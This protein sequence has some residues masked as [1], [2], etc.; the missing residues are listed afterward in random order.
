MPRAP[1]WKEKQSAYLQRCSDRMLSSGSLNT[2]RWALDQFYYYAVDNGFP[3]NPSKVEPNHVRE[4]Y[5]HL[6]DTGIRTATQ[7]SY[8]NALLSFLRFCG[9]G[10]CADIRMKI[11]VSRTNVN[12]LSEQEVA[13]LISTAKQ[14]QLRAALVLMAYLGLRRGE[15]VHLQTK[16]VG[17][18]KLTVLGKGRKERVLPLD[19]QFWTAL[20]PYTDWLQGRPSCEHFL[21]WQGLD[22][23]MH[24]Y[25]E[26]S[27]NSFVRRHS[28][29]LG[30]RVTPHTLRRSFG[31]HL[32]LHGCPLAELQNLMGH[33]SIDMTIKYL[34]IGS[35]DITRAIGYRPD[36]LGGIK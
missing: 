5:F 32:Y 7:Q 21:S 18:S 15:V 13:R 22:G 19:Q 34:G 24:G 36:Y 12:W 14:P 29:A 20:K 35:D 11:S 31:R 27:L 30:L 17:M 26:K 16:N 10:S 6:V 2:Y 28:E 3:L 1:P 33:A 23:Q 9:N 8:M 4:F 25:Q